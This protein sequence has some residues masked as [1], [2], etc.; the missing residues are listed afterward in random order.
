V[1][2]T[3]DVVGHDVTSVGRYGTAEHRVI[4]GELGKRRA[5]SEV[6]YDD[7]PVP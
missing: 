2:V 3:G 7:S 1:Y 4:A 5:G 6:P